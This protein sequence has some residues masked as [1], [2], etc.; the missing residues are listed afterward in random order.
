MSAQKAL[1]RSEAE[2]FQSTISPL[3][4]TG[5][6][7][8]AEFFGPEASVFNQSWIVIHQSDCKFHGLSVGDDEIRISLRRD[9]VSQQKVAAEKCTS[10]GS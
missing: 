8:M 5:L 4:N 7:T 1:R 3:L 2:I 10:G 6:G 9:D